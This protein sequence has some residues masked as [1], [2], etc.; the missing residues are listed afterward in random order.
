M[1]ADTATLGHCYRTPAKVRHGERARSIEAKPLDCGCRNARLLQYF[2]HR[3]T[4][5]LPYIVRGLL[6]N[7]VVM[8]ITPGDDILR[9][10]CFYLTVSCNERCASRTGTDINADEVGRVGTHWNRRDYGVRESE[11]SKYMV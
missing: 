3:G 4:N 6:E 9:G 10:R 8:L 7:T 2:L 1:H 5:L 11:M